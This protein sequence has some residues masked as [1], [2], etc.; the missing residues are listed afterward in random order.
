VLSCTIKHQ[1]SHFIGKRILPDHCWQEGLP[2]HIADCWSEGNFIDVQNHEGFFSSQS[3]Q[4]RKASGLRVVLSAGH[5]NAANSAPQELHRMSDRGQR[6][7]LLPSG[8][9]T[10]F[11]YDATKPG[12]KLF[13]LEHYAH[14]PSE[15]V[16]P[17]G[18]LLITGLTTT[19]L[20]MRRIPD[21]SRG[22]DLSIPIDQAGSAAAALGVGLPSSGRIQGAN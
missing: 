8:R 16:D 19:Y 13:H 9:S 15:T 12:A 21:C 4:L 10:S 17:A 11:R 5:L 22:G 6:T 2:P 1:L 7:T 18:Q 14:Q 3:P 20:R